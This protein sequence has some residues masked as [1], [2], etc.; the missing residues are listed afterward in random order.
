MLP[1]KSRALG[2]SVMLIIGIGCSDQTNYKADH[3]IHLRSATATEALQTI[4]ETLGQEV[5]EDIS[6]QTTADTLIAAM[7]SA[8]VEKGALLSVA[9][10]FAM[11]EVD[12]DDEKA[13]VRSENEFTAEQASRYPDRLAAFCSFNPLA[14]YATEE[15]QNCGEDGQFTGLKLHLANSDVNLQNADELNRLTEI[16][17]MANDY[18][19]A[20]VIHLWTRNPD[21]GYEDA[22]LFIDHVLTEAPDIPVQI[23]HMGGPSGFNDATDNASAAFRD[24]FEEHPERMEHVYLDLAAVPIPVERAEGDTETEQQIREMNQQAETRIREIGPEHI[25]PATDW[26]SGSADTFGEKYKT[27]PFDEELRNQIMHNVAP[28]F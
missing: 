21:Y 28:Y 1:L 14:D 23:A 4:Q 7:D 19:L 2:L 11:P 15:L 26:I 5:S 20:V 8:G 10:F 17:R 22:E 25:L 18:E 3:H 6:A 24:A 12:F 27:L 13:L 9:Y 16:F